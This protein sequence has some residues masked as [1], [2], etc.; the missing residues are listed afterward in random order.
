LYGACAWDRGVSAT[1]ILMNDVAAQSSP[2][3]FTILSTKKSL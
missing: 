1:G 2:I 3:M